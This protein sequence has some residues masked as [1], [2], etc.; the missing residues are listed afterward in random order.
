MIVA[1][2]HEAHGILG[3]RA[4]AQTSLLRSP[5]MD[6]TRPLRLVYHRRM[7]HRTLVCRPMHKPHIGGNILQSKYVSIPSLRVRRGLIQST[8]IAKPEKCRSH[9]SWQGHPSILDRCQCQ[10]TQSYKRSRCAR[11][12]IGA[13]G[14]PIGSRNTPYT[15]RFLVWEGLWHTPLQGRH[16]RDT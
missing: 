16:H 14:P 2:I 15:S 8:R 1:H 5:P 13:L 11:K 12:N 7:Q 3:T 4:Y 6:Q 9:S 10:Q